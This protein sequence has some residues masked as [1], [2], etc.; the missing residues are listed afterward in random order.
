MRA[1]S[2]TWN[3][4]LLNRSHEKLRPAAHR[5]RRHHRIR[6]LFHFNLTR[7]VYLALFT[8]F[9]IKWEEQLKRIKIQLNEKNGGYNQIQLN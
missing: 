4:R 3:Q 5:W 6:Q 8:S 7:T 1:A 2:L 9:I